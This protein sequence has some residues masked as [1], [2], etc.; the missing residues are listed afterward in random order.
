MKTHAYI[1]S[2]MRTRTYMQT[3][4][5]TPPPVHQILGL[6][7]GN[8][9]QNKCDIEHRTDGRHIPATPHFAHAVAAASELSAVGPAR[10]GSQVTVA[11]MRQLIPVMKP[12]NGSI[13]STCNSEL[14][15]ER[16]LTVIGT[17]QCISA[18]VQLCIHARMCACVCVRACVH[19]RMCV[20][21]F[22]CVCVCVC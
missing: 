21:I 1:Q 3:Q 13:H 22:L 9:T 4:T 10:W 17:H 15:P 16:L 5:Y 7:R 18:C 12:G 6:R 14:L 11:V 20:R 2:H 19:K 8:T